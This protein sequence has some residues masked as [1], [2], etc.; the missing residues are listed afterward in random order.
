M[1]A[2]HNIVVPCDGS[3][4]ASR[5]AAYGLTLAK[6]LG[7]RL[8]LVHVFPGT[9][10]ELI[11]MPG[12]S[13]QMVGIGRFDDKTFKR[14]WNE[15]AGLSLGKAEQAL[16]EAGKDAHSERLSGDPASE[17]IRYAHGLD[18][19]M[20]VIG[21]RGLGAMKEMLLGSVSHRVVHKAK[22]PVTVVH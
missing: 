3:D 6:A 18:S 5:A 2:I 10:E 14:L 22:C 1:T 9:P 11:G 12:A 19:P 21:S 8:H 15:A 13:A 16:G 4:T 20:I 7:A 17:I